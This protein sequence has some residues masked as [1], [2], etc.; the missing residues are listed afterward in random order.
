MTSQMNILTHFYCDASSLSVQIHSQR[1]D[2]CNII[3]YKIKIKPLKMLKMVLKP[4]EQWNNASN[5]G[6]NKIWLF[7]ECACAFR[8]KVAKVYFII[9]NCGTFVI[10]IKYT[11]N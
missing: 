6:K 3:S 10:S 4:Q 1:R 2:W 7:E 11:I 5:A 9:E 8:T